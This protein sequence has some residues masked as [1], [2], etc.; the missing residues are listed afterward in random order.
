MDTRGRKLLLDNSAAKS[1]YDDPKLAQIVGSG[2]GFMDVP[3]FQNAQGVCEDFLREVR[4]LVF[5]R[6]EKENSREFLEITPV[7]CWITIPAIWSDE[8]KDATRAAAK[9]AGFASRPMDS[10]SMIPEPEAAAIATLKKYTAPGAANHIRVGFS[11]L[12]FRN[13]LQC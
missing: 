13:F 7:D 5:A 3:S 9:A 2:K 10:I 11:Y 8:A 1:D 4:K 6:L 12:H